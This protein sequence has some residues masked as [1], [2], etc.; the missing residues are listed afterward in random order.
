[1]P[2]A[3]TRRTGKRLTPYAPHTGKRVDESMQD[4]VAQPPAGRHVS[5][6]CQ[7]VD[8]AMS[9]AP[10]NQ[11]EGSAVAAEGGRIRRPA[12]SLLREVSRNRSGYQT[13][14]R[15]RQRL[16]RPR[17]ATRPSKD[18][19]GMSNELFQKRVVRAATHTYAFTVYRRGV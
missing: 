3:T 1:V 12:L 11:D 15:Q 7:S 6:G 4:Q 2:V 13:I 14:I 17:H 8:A 5:P 19:G 18:D 9:N 10:R 16:P